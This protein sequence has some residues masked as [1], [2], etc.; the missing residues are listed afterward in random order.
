[1]CFYSPTLINGVSLGL[2]QLMT[3]LR[4]Q[5]VVSVFREQDVHGVQK[6]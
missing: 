4:E 3:V 2:Y 6:R 5:S 1:M